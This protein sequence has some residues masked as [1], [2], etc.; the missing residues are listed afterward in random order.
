MNG[1]CQNELYMIVE[2]LPTST[3]FTFSN[4][5]YLQ[6]CNYVSAWLSSWNI[7]FSQCLLFKVV[8]AVCENYNVST[9]R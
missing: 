8:Y 2:L 5:L 9:V 1:Y 3:F 7:P 4:R 6:L